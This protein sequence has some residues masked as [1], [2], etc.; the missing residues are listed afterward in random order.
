MRTISITISQIPRYCVWMSASHKGQFIEVTCTGTPSDA[1]SSDVHGV[2]KCQN[3]EQSRL[4][5]ITQE[6]ARKLYYLISV[7][8]SFFLSEYM[9]TP[10]S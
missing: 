2:R 7:F 6:K 1:V 4:S 3:V 10:W 5:W 8:H 9:K